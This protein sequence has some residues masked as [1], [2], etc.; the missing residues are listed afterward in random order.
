MIE[1]RKFSAN[2]SL[3]CSI[4]SVT[5]RLA[6]LGRGL[7]NTIREDG[8]CGV[9]EM[10]KLAGSDGFAGTIGAIE[11]SARMCTKHNSRVRNFLLHFEQR[12]RL[13]FSVSTG[14]FSLVD[15]VDP[16]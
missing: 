11:C 7:A 16:F 15:A 9:V 2:G 10:D 8:S 3:S 4:V 12:Y 13:R 14:G 6:E 5:I 1:V